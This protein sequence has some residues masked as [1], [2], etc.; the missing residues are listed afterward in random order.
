MLAMRDK[1]LEGIKRGGFTKGRIKMHWRLVRTI[2]LILSRKRGWRRDSVTIAQH[3][4]PPFPAGFLGCGHGIRGVMGNENC[5]EWVRTRIK[6]LLLL[7]Q[8]QLN[9]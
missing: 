5:V 8:P 1:P 4:N 9:S 3:I 2:I 7:I 6:P